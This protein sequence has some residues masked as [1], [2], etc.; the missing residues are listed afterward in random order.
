[1]FK[2]GATTDIVCGGRGNPAT[3]HVDHPALAALTGSQ[4][5]SAT[6]QYWSMRPWESDRRQ[7]VLARTRTPT[8]AWT[9]KHGQ[10]D[11]SL[12]TKREASRREMPAFNVPSVT[13]L[14]SISDR[15]QFWSM[16]PWESGR[17]QYVLARTRTPT[18]AWTG[19][20]DQYGGASLKKC[21]QGGSRFHRLAV[22]GRHSGL[23]H[24]D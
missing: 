12:L 19:K 23:R 16:R 5:L 17:R 20:R 21:K 8:V 3:S 11:G 7:H 18:I 13:G 15:L 4:P 14:S 1:M 22:G 9:S 2:V 6:F 10:Y 24:G